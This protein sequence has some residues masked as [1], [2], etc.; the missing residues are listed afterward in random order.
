MKHEIRNYVGDKSD[1]AWHGNPKGILCCFAWQ[2]RQVGVTN[3]WAEFFIFWTIILHILGLFSSQIRPSTLAQICDMHSKL[4]FA[5]KC[6]KMH[7]L[8]YFVHKIWKH[9]KMTLN[10]KI[11]KE[12]RHKCTRTSQLSRINML[13]SNSPTLSFC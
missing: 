9:T 2:W 12:T 3:F 7:L 10:I 6:S 13:L 4:H 5:P 11:T 8:A 1:Q